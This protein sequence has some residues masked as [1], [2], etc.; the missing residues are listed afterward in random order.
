VLLL[1]LLVLIFGPVALIGYVIDMP[2]IA[3]PVLHAG[4]KRGEFWSALVSLPSFFV[5]RLVNSAMML[6]A[7]FEE[8]VLRRS[9][10][11]YEKG[12]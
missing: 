8:V 9:F 7:V 4:A 10:D 12:H 1:P 6:R 11:T 3:V 2:A 5:L